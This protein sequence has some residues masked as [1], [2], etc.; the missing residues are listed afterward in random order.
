M[1]TLALHLLAIV[2]SAAD[3]AA[4]PENTL[5][6]ELVTKGVQMPDGEVVKL[7]PVTMAEGLTAAEQTEVLTRTATLGTTTLAK[8]LNNGSNQAI[9]LKVRRINAAKN[10][11]IIRTVNLY[12]VVYGDWNVLTSDEFSRSILKPNNG[13][14]KQGMVVEAGYLK[15]TEIAVRRLS[16]RQDHD[17]LK[18]YYLYTNLKLFGDDD[19]VQSR[20]T[21]FCVATRTPTGVIVAARVDP[22]FATDKEK[23]YPNQWNEIIKSSQGDATLGP[24]KPYSGAAFYAKVTR[25]IAPKDAIFV[26][27]HQA[28]YEPRAWF[29]VD[30]NLTPSE[31]RKIIPF[32]VH[33]FRTKLANATLK[34][35]EK[36]VAVQK[37]PEK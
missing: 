25:L 31:L 30:E 21:R 24:A 13:K 16:A 7:P 12:F 23:E 6:T 22:R 27:L 34:A 19:R 1:N 3:P 28:F 36:N 33:N 11:D 29:G 4:A 37:P 8:F 18:E 32:E 15:P 2:V 10:N 35:A 9:T 14:K 20:A 17:L 26:E 5:L